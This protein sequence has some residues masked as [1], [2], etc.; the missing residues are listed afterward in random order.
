MG[1]DDDFWKVIGL[2]I[3]GA[4]GLALL[5][6]AISKKT[7]G[8]SRVTCPYCS[9]TFYSGISPSTNLPITCPH[10]GRQIAR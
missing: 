10:C 9:S 5:A 7:P 8:P 6:A 1:E 4:L 3:A 2:I